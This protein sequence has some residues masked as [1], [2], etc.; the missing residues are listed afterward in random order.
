[1]IRTTLLLGGVAALL[2]TA[3]NAQVVAGATFSFNGAATANGWTAHS[4]GGAKVINANGSFATLDQSIGSG[5]DINL[6]FAPFGAADTMYA[7][8][9]LNVPAGNPVNPDGQGLYFIHFKDA[10][11][12]F[13]ARTGLLS[14]AA[15]GD[16]QLA[17]HADSADLGLG[18]AWPTDLSFGTDYTVVFSWDAATNTSSLWLNPTQPTD[19]SITSIGTLPVGTLISAIALRQSN[20]YT[21]LIHVD[22]VQVGRTFADVLGQ[23]PSYYTFGAGCPSS[24]GIATNTSSA[25]PQIGSVW[26]IEIGNVPAP[27]AVLL[28][29]GSSNLGGLDLGFLGAPGCSAF[30]NIDLLSTLAFGASG[31]VQVNNFVPAT[32]AFVGLPVYTQAAVFELG[33]NGLNAVV[34]NAAVAQVG[35]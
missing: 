9:T 6:A 4:G 21:G 3:A 14:P 18:A 33:I 16:F 13:R 10:T 27:E 28:Y 25:L 20:D 34:S 26:S 19:P 32:P 1:M 7:S 30:A 12:T 22:N 17:I 23:A 35:S 29:Y 5:E 2:S 31:T 11:T 8:F 15:G 24:V